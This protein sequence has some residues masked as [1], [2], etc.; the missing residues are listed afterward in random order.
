MD[1]QKF[2]N[3]IKD[4]FSKTKQIQR[5]Q[6]YKYMGFPENWN[7]IKNISLEGIKNKSLIN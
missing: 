4:L 7:D 6:L 1:C 5:L 3:F 2:K